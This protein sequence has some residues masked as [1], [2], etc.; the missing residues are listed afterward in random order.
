[1]R[2]IRRQFGIFLCLMMIILS[3]CSSGG[4]GGGGG[5]AGE[6]SAVQDSSKQGDASASPTSDTTTNSSGNQEP[7]TI[8]F[9]MFFPDEMLK[10]AKLKYEEK[11][12]NITIDLQ[13]VESD[14]AHMEAELEKYVKT[15]NTAMLSGK[16]PDL[17]MLDMLPA[18]KYVG[19]HLLADLSDWLKQD[20]AFNNGDYFNNILENSRT[21]DGLYS[22]PLGFFLNALVGDGAAIKQTGIQIDDQSWT[23]ESFADTA[24]KLK[25]H[26]TGQAALISQP[27]YLLGE[28]VKENYRKFVDEENRKAYFDTAAF[29]DLMQQVKTLFGDG[30][31]MNAA[32]ATGPVNAY[33]QTLN[34]NSAWDYLVTLKESGKEAKLYAK[35]RAEDAKAGGYFYTYKSIGINAKSTVKQEAWDFLQFLMSEEMQPAPER[36]G[37]PINK[38]V[39]EKQVQQL[40]NEGTFK[41]YE[42][43]PLKGQSFPIDAEELQRLSYYLTEAVHPTPFQPT[44]IEEMVRND[45]QAFFSGQ[46]SAE[47]VAKLIQNKVMTYLNE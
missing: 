20:P 44:K 38:K 7:K 37:F 15:T 31:V 29:T 46:K 23:W 26:G 35:P 40:I 12:P 30:I 6:G 24:G 28:M 45:S 14:N 13:Y 5:N 32:E 25:Q 41:T 34:I 18:E 43:G 42:E 17:I 27:K 9:S 22:V 4:N 3:A 2:M 33:F 36:A 11:H 47:D 10:E 16:G 19:Q 21:G 39:Y 8:V 1:M